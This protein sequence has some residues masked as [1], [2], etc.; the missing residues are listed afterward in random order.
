MNTDREVSRHY[1]AG[2][3]L[4]RLNAALAEDGIDPDRVI[5]GGGSGGTGGGGS[6]GRHVIAVGADA[7]AQP[8]VNVYDAQSGALRLVILAYAARFRGG[9]R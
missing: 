9:V 8:R 4:S 2:D 3:L 5:T 6:N 7:G 1:G